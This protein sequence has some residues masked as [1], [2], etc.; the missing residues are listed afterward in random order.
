MHVVSLMAENFL[1]LKAIEIKPK[2]RLVRLTGKNAQGK[3]SALTAIAVAL[4]GADAEPAVSVRKGTTQS[5]IRLD[6]GDVIVTKT[7]RANGDGDEVSDVRVESA[8]GARFPRPQAMLDALRGEE[9]VDPL[10]FLRM[11]PK[12][13]F[14]KLR[15]FVEGFDFDENEKQRKDVYDRRTEVNRFAREAKAAASM[16]VVPSDTPEEPV[17]Q[18][19]LEQELQRAGEHN[20]QIEQR[21]ARREQA[22]TEIKAKREQVVSIAEQIA[23]LEDQIR[24]LRE[25][26]AMIAKAAD[27]LEEDL[28]NAP[29]LPDPID[30]AEILSR[31]SKA[32]QVNANVDKLHSRRKH[33]SLATQYEKQAEE[34]T[35]QIA[36]LMQAKQDAI[37]KAHLPVDGI[38]FGDGE[39]LLNGLPFDQASMAE[40]LRTSIAIAMAMKPKLRVIWIQ[41]ASLFDDDSIAIIEEMAE[42]HDYQIWLEMVDSSGKIGFRF[43]QG[44]ITAVD[45]EPVE[46]PSLDLAPAGTTAPA[47]KGRKSTRKP[48]TGAPTDGVQA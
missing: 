18:A 42:K 41:D 38:G 44:Q 17:D 28:A 16:I 19:A 48:W 22:R 8:E 26:S 3:T 36:A 40:K 45:G 25:R 32:R 34:L 7:I 5:R 21:K 27:K 1:C 15:V 43:E 20:T 35:D 46:Q 24:G 37:A 2:G 10:A 4:E 31:M 33:E 47:P 14:N 11:K 39:V 29:L 12:D 30:T 9:A 13:Q 6:L 23:E